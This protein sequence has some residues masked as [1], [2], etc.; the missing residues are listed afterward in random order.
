[1]LAGVVA[2]AVG[3]IAFGSEAFL[4]LPAFTLVSGWDYQMYGVGYPVLEGAIHGDYVVGLLLA[5]LAGKIIATSLTMAIGGP[6]ASSRPPSSSA[7]CWA[8]PSASGR[9]TSCPE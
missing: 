3:R 4:T 5:F 7:R 1:M 9:M 2:T 6:V 8:A